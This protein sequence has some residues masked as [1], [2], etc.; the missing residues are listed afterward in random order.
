MPAVRFE[1]QEVLLLF[2]ARTLKSG[3]L[4]TCSTQDTQDRW[5]NVMECL[6][7]A[8]SVRFSQ[9][10][11]ILL[12]KMALILT[13]AWETVENKGVPICLPIDKG[14][15]TLNC[16]APEGPSH[17]LDLA[18]GAETNMHALD[19]AIA[20]LSR[21]LRHC[22]E[23]EC[24]SRKFLGPFNTDLNEACRLM[25]VACQAFEECLPPAWQT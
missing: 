5:H 14:N 1:V 7:L 22:R 21:L 15:V 8:A 23:A 3:V 6:R 13:C 19:Q 10:D 4:L 12:S 11:R 9:P 17:L 16:H 20:D 18:H 24:D 25:E 2:L